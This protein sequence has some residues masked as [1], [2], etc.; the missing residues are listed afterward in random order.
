MSDPP[1]HQTSLSDEG[2]KMWVIL[3]PKG[4]GTLEHPELQS[5]KQPRGREL[6]EIGIQFGEA[7]E[8][9]QH[10]DHNQ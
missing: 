9:N 10:P 1:L 6:N 3:S 7:I 4:A 2:L 8:E 5:L